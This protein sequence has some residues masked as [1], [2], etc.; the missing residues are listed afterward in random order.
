MPEAR[1]PKRPPALFSIVGTINL[2]Q[3]GGKPAEKCF[4]GPLWAPRNNGLFAKSVAKPK[5]A[6]VIT[7]LAPLRNWSF[8]VAAAIIL[9]RYQNTQTR[10]IGKLL[11]NKGHTVTLAQAEKLI[12]ATH[13][14]NEVTGMCGGVFNN[15]L[16]METGI[17]TNP[18]TVCGFSCRE[19]CHVYEYLFVRT[20]PSNY[21]HRLLIPNL[22]LENF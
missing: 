15:F 22:N 11:I 16:F 18:V 10:E 9:K 5:D 14:Q 21:N 6:C 19:L 13:G 4:T 12:E 7:V 8:V 20:P 2:A 17:P 3:T 1:Q